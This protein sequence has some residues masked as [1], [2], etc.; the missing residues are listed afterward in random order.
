MLFSII[1]PMYNVEQYIV[2]CVESVY[3]NNLNS[4]LFEIILIDDESPDNSVNIIKE[5][6][7][8][9]KYVNFQIHSQ[10]NKGLG[11]A[12][13]TGIKNAKGNLLIF[14]D[15]DDILEV[16]LKML[17]LFLNDFDFDILELS[18]NI[19]D[20]NLLVKSFFRVNDNL[21]YI[22]G[23]DYYLNQK[24]I[25]SVCNKIYSKNFLQKHDLIFEEQI[26]IED[27]EF[28]TRAFYF[29]KK[30]ISK[31]II[32]QSFVQ[33]NNSIT[34][35]HDINKKKKLVYDLFIVTQKVKDFGVNNR[36]LNDKYFTDRLSRLNV[37][38]IFQAFKYNFN[39]KEINQIIVKL[40]ET[41]LYYLNN[42]IAQSN[43]NL[44]RMLVIYT[45]LLFNILIKL[46]NE[47]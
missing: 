23:V 37:N 36:S 7:N 10:K 11:G 43:K 34:R 22:N 2:R 29:A 19:L 9:N 46:K 6:L 28:N 42:K 18:N 15:A 21:N 14:L 4:E 45:P 25:P 5:Y 16:D 47:R 44:F 30:V 26:Y 3:K 38:Q 12:R 40:K 35:N 33:T 39:R 20:D 27:F 13:N 32:L 41:D 31:N 1:I 24:S 8:K 17:D